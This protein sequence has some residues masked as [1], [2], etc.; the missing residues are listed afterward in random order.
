MTMRLPR[1]SPRAGRWSVRGRQPGAYASPQERRERQGAP[2]RP[3]HRRRVPIGRTSRPAPT[4]RRMEA[5]P[6]A[7]GGTFPDLQ[8][9]YRSSARRPASSSSWSA[10]RA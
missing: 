6:E 4:C 9:P 3:L 8:A 7:T 5:I 10:I 1:D 2:N